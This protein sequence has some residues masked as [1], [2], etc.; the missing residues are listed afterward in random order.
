MRAWRRPARSQQLAW[1]PQH[2]TLRTAT[3]PPALPAVSETTLLPLPRHRTPPPAQ[4]GPQPQ[5]PLRST[6]PHTAHP[7]WPPRSRAWTPPAPP[8]LTQSPQHRWL[9]SPAWRCRI[10]LHRSLSRRR[11][12]A[13][14]QRQR[15]RQ[16]PRPQGRRQRHRRQTQGRRRRHRTARAEWQHPLN[17]RERGWWSQR[18]RG[19]PG[20]Q[21]ERECCCWRLRQTG[22][23]QRTESMQHQT[24]PL[25]VWRSR[26]Q[27]LRLRHQ[28]PAC[29]C[30]R[31]RGWRPQR[32]TRESMPPRTLTWRHRR[33]AQRSRRGRGWMQ[34]WLRTGSLPPPLQPGQTR[35]W[36][37]AALQR[38][39]AQLPG[40][41][42]LPRQCLRAG[43]DPPCRPS[44]SPPTAAPPRTCPCSWAWRRWRRSG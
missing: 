3:K 33:P 18:G 35:E 41:T 43:W 13:G 22:P 15:Q 10:G 42:S 28:R 39:R 27:A 1:P 24:G 25:Q 36:Q 34:Q 21:R 14:R 44:G 12:R 26:T 4:T 16:A 7:Q 31:G 32:Q 9:P 19:R 29:C 37:S 11:E 6:L 8:S 38:A 17:R 2:Q 20:R 5:L 40:R 23:R 30:R